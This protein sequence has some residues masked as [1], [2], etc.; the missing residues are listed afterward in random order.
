M[1]RN[2]PDESNSIE[3]ENKDL[4]VEDI[5]ALMFEDLSQN[6]RKLSPLQLWNQE[7]NTYQGLPRADYKVEPLFW[8]KS[9]VGQF[10]NLGISFIIL[11][12]HS[13]IYL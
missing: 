12:G 3:V 10:P 2:V 13:F 11:L 1:V 6:S 5:F 7:I 4:P 8:W 9:N